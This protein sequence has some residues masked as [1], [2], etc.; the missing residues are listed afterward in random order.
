MSYTIYISET[1]LGR[2]TF[3]TKEELDEWIN[4][5]REYDLVKWYSTT[6]GDMEIIHNETG[7]TVEL[8]SNT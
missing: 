8:D 4:G 5:E 1:N 3:E 2:V 6:D 7:K